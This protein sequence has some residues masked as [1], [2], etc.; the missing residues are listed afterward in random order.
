MNLTQCL[1]Y[2]LI[3][4]DKLNVM[5]CKNV[6]GSGYKVLNSILQDPALN[7]DFYCSKCYEKIKKELAEKN[8][9]EKNG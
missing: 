4:K 9:T 1:K 5:E 7:R 2:L 6:F 8:W 3:N